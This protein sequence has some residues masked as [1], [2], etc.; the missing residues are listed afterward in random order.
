MGKMPLIKRSWK[1][2][3][4]RRLMELAASGETIESVARKMKRSPLSIVRKA[5]RLG[6]SLK[7]TK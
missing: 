3:E 1:W 2:S 4:D 5:V 7:A 6:I